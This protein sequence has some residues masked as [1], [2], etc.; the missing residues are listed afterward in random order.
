MSFDSFSDLLAMGGHALYVWLSYGVSLIVI[1]WNAW[2]V[3]SERVRFF[4]DAR[5]QQRR[6]AAAAQSGRSL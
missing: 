1:V 4:R 6:N 5:A 2:R 3:R